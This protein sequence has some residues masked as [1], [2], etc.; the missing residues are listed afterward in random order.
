MEAI[1]FTFVILNVK[2]ENS[3][4]AKSFRCFNIK[5]PPFQFLIFFS[6]GKTCIDCES[7]YF[8]HSLE[9]NKFFYACVA[10]KVIGKMYLEIS[11]FQNKTKQ[12]KNIFVKNKISA[13][14]E[15][16]VSEKKTYLQKIIKSLS[17]NQVS[18]SNVIICLNKVQIKIH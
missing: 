17:L 11:V 3:F 5:L 12:N 7:K 9:A 6:G 18:A 14:K 15:N 10:N 16:H 2:E 4:E 13:F 1:S 8:N